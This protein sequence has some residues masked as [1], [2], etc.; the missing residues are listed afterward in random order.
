ME[1]IFQ[2][3]GTNTSFQE[4]E[5]SNP[6][7]TT[8]PFQTQANSAEC[9]VSAARPTEQKHNL[10]LRSQ[11]FHPFLLKIKHEVLNFKFQLEN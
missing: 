7:Q 4:K 11:D 2:Q 5:S 1:M 3:L 10:P 8:Q 9:L 6:K